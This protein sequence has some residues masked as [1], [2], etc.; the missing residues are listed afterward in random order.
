M[1]SECV[2]YN[3]MILFIIIISLPLA[4]VLPLLLP[5]TN[6]HDIYAP[7]GCSLEYKV[8]G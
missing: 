1:Q 6:D 7:E 5:L 4:R 2:M 8:Y 3:T